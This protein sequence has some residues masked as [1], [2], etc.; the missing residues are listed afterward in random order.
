MYDPNHKTPR[1]SGRTIPTESKKR[2]TAPRN[3]QTTHIHVSHR[4][5]T[6]LYKKIHARPPLRIIR[7]SSTIKVHETNGIPTSSWHSSSHTTELKLRRFSTRGL[8]RPEVAPRKQP[9]YDQ[10]IT[11]VNINTL[12]F[13]LADKAIGSE[14]SM[15]H[16]P[17]YGDRQGPPDIYTIGLTISNYPIKGRLALEDRQVK[18]HTRP[19]FHHLLF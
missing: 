14:T 9:L 17:T 8:P 5:H 6:Y 4:L 2:Y 18:L 3:S 10:E 12:R 1:E 11:S 16:L 13:P 19:T 7:P 15:I